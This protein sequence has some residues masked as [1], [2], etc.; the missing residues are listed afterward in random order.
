MTSTATHSRS[1]SRSRRRTAVALVLAGPA[2]SACTLPGQAP[3]P[4][5]SETTRPADAT[6]ESL[7][8]PGTATTAAASG[9]AYD[10]RFVA[11]SAAACSV[12]WTPGAVLPET[13]EWCSDEE[14]EPVAGVRIGS[15]EV[16]THRNEMYA[17][18]GERISA[19]LGEI[20][21]DP[22]FVALL[23]SCK[24]RPAVRR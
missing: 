20:S 8:S 4:V 11:S 18:P 23:T 10:L 19:S 6:A 15:C 21:Q 24:R 12:V 17:V 3:A 7:P 2:L 14:G 16:I 13:Y 9:M 22:Q 5:E 1:R